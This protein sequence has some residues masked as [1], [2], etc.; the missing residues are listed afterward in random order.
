MDK[1]IEK[2]TITTTS[3]DDEEARLVSINDSML[4]VEFKQAATTFAKWI[5]PQM[6]Q[7]SADLLWCPLGDGVALPAI[8]IL[9]HSTFD[10]R[11]QVELKFESDV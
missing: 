1:F 7:F 8:D 2:K 10:L 6:I 5:K 4:S 11:L 9:P 3:V